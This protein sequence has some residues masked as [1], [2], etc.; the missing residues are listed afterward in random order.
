MA[1]VTSHSSKPD[2]SLAV[3]TSDWGDED[4]VSL[5]LNRCQIDTPKPLVASMWEHVAGYRDQIN[6][7]VD[8]GAG[9]GRFSAS[10]L[11]GKYIG[12]EI[13][14]RRC[15]SVG[16]NA[17]IR[18]E[19]AF[20]TSI[21][22]AD[23][24]IGNPPFV[25]NQD[26][27]DGWRNKVAKV[28]EKR[29]G[30]KLSGLAN[31]WQYFF[32]LGLVSIKSD[33]LCVLI[34]PFEWVSRPSAG[35]IRN[36]IKSNQWN[37][38]VYR[39]SDKTFSSVLTTASITV[40]DKLQRHGRWRYFEETDVGKFRPVPS[41]CGSNE[42][43]LPYASKSACTLETPRAT[44]GL[45]PGSQ[46][47]F[48]LTEGERIFNGL[49]LRSD[50]IACVTSLRPL[51]NDVTVLDQT[52]FDKFYR[53]AGQKCWLIRTDKCMSKRLIAY[54][55]SLP[56]E[57]YQTK[58]CR[59][60]DIWWNFRMP[61]TPDVLMAQT[62]KQGFPKA[63]KN[64]VGAKAVGGVCGIYNLT[65]AQINELVSGL[66]GMDFSDRIVSYANGLHKIEINQLNYVL[67]SYFGAES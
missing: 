18:K 60:R 47:V 22:D 57:L 19:C 8:F 41:P 9:D 66:D 34:I 63:V 49:H 59:E 67:T 2:S 50:V 33:G 25:R 6:T 21:S 53:K 39:L 17:V 23:L 20:S 1:Y 3:S 43:V 61:N 37:V 26:I 40:V 46:K 58:T 28:L 56:E 54:V 35:N 55:E 29:A 13:D 5:F 36:Y 24:C 16:R 27:P 65:S 30:V 48:V 32:L 11:Y 42:G 4:S 62:F 10:G 15:G 64:V 38:D 52:V 12:Y 44:R 14:N 51:P 7:A 31:A 45:S